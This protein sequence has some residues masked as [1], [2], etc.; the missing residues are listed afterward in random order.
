MLN[1]RIGHLETANRDLAT[2]LFMLSSSILNTKCRSW[3]DFWNWT[4]WLC[5]PV[6]NREVM[7]EEEAHALISS[8]ERM[9]TVENGHEFFTP[10]TWWWG[11]RHE[12]VGAGT[13]HLPGV[14]GSCSAPASSSTRPSFSP[15]RK[16]R[17]QGHHPHQ[18]TSIWNIYKMLVSTW[19]LKLQ[20]RQLI[21]VVKSFLWPNLTFK[22]C[23]FFKIK[24][25]L[26]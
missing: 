20:L 17:E 1:L 9:M 2:W 15:P 14:S 12:A 5:L 19:I 24:S 3:L 7:L 13:P 6:H 8:T 21:H 18:N 25:L 10:G 23:T 16:T 11:S 26:Q 22:I 4:A